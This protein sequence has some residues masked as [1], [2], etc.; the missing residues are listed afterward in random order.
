MRV[1]V[2][3]GTGYLGRAI[4]RALTARGHHPVV[5]SRHA[6][7]SGTAADTID[8]DVRDESTLRRAAAGTDAIIHTAALVS[9]WHA[10][11]SAFDEVNVGG[12][13]TTLAAARALGIGRVVY[14]SS[15]LAHPPADGQASIAAND[16]Q[17]TKV[18]AG[19]IARDAIRAG[20]P[21]VS[22]VPGVIYGPGPATEGNLIGRMIADHLAG[23]LPGVIGGHR[24]WS[25]A[26]VDDVAEAHVRAL[27]PHVEPGEYLLG[28]EN[29]PPM[30]VFEIVR[31]RLGRPLPRQIPIPLAVM[32]AVVEE[33]R[34]R[35]ARRPPA[36]TRGI[37]QIFR[38]DWSMNS[39]RSVEKLS[40]RITPLEVGVSALL[41]ARP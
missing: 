9:L 15:F 40:Y 17:R 41:S 37:V 14:T 1:L 16:Y 4:V 31:D 8:G 26:F 22:L 18:R 36:I 2:T 34:A 39:A 7:Q 20:M 12:L 29:A 24:R 35:A 21:L 25:Y 11:P 27:L 33:M 3:G 6:S 10:R 38:H 13:Q 32:A 30:R 23:R 28:G 5:F 19:E